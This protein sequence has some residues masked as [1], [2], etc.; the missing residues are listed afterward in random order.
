MRVPLLELQKSEGL[1]R[2]GVRAAGP[3]M[4]RAR[5]FTGGERV[6]VRR[7]EDDERR[8]FQSGDGTKEASAGAVKGAPGGACW[9]G[10][11]VLGAGGAVGGDDMGV[12]NSMQC[13]GLGVGG[14][15]GDS[16]G[17]AGCCGSQLLSHNAS[18]LT[19]AELGGAGPQLP[20]V[21]SSLV[22]CLAGQ[23][24][25]S[26]AP[27]PCET[28]ETVTGRSS[29]PALVDPAAAALSALGAGD[30]TAQEP[31]SQ[32]NGA[33]DAPVTGWH[34]VR[35]D[36]AEDKWM[37]RRPRVR[38]RME[39]NPW[40]QVQDVTWG[41]LWAGAQKR[42]GEEEKASAQSWVSRAV[43]LQLSWAV[44][45]STEVLRVRL[46]VK[47]DEWDC[48]LRVHGGD[49]PA[50]SLGDDAIRAMAHAGWKTCARTWEEGE[51]ERVEPREEGGEVRYG[52]EEM[53]DLLESSD[54]EGSV[55]SDSDSDVEDDAI[56]NARARAARRE[57]RFWRRLVKR[58][59]RGAV[60][61]EEPGGLVSGKQ[62]E[63]PT[64]VLRD[65]E[66]LQKM[67]QDEGC[68]GLEAG[69]L[70]STPDD[71]PEEFKVKPKT[72]KP[73]G[74]HEEMEE[75]LKI[76]P[77]CDSEVLRWIKDK[78]VVRAPEAAQGCRMRNGKVARDQPLAL[79]Q[80]MGKRL[81]NGTFRCASQEDCVNLVSLN[82]VDKP[83]AEPPYRLTVW[84]KDLNEALSKWSVRYEGVHKLG[85][86][87]W[88]GAW[89]VCIDL[90]SGYDAMGLEESTKHLFAARFYAEAEFIAEL[91]AE[92]LLVEGCL[93]EK[94]ASGGA[95]VFVEPNTL[96]QGFSWACA[97]FSKCVRQMVREWR[98]KGLSVCHLIDD[99]LFAFK[100]YA[101]AIWGRDYI[102]SYLEAK[103]WCVS[104]LKAVLTPTQRLKFLGF[105]VDT[106]K[107]RLFLD[108]QKVVKIEAVLQQ[109][110]STG[111]LQETHRSLASV[112]GK[113]VATGPAIPPAR[114]LTRHIYKDVS[115]E[116]ADYDQP[117][118]VRPE[119]LEEMQ[120]AL[121]YLRRLNKYGG[122]IRRKARMCQMRV[123]SDASQHGY[124][125]RIDGRDVRDLKWNKRSRAV[126]AQ[127]T[128]EW[129]HQVHRELAAVREALQKEAEHLRGK[130]V[131]WFTDARAVET[132]INEG[133]GSSDVMSEM[134]ADI[135][136][137]CAAEG[138][139]LRAEHMAGVRMVATGVDSMSRA[140]EFTMHARVYA[141]LNR[142]PRWGRRW[143]FTGFEV[144]LCASQKTAKCE[145]YY[146]RGGLGEGSLG[147]ARTA[148][149]RKDE[150]HYVVPPT[151]FVE[152]A[153]GLLAETGVAAIVVVPMWVGK[154]WNVWLRYR[155]EDIEELPWSEGQPTW[156][157]VADKKAKPHIVANQ[158]QFVVFAVDFRQ[159]ER[160]REEPLKA[161]R[162]QK[163]KQ[164]QGT[165]TKRLRVRWAADEKPG[166]QGYR[167]WRN[168]AVACA[169]SPQSRP[170]GWSR[171]TTGRVAMAAPVNMLPARCSGS[172]R[173]GQL[174]QRRQQF[175]VLSLCGGIGT[176]ALALQQVFEIFKVNMAVV[177]YEVEIHE[178]ARRLGTKLGGAALKHKKPH[179]LWEWIEREEEM[180]AWLQVVQPE[181]FIMGFSCQDVSTAF[182]KGRG[183][184]GPKSSIYF[185]GRTI[186]KWALEESRL[187]GSNRQ[188]DSTY[189]CTW[190]KEKHP[191]DW[192]LVTED[193]GCEPQCLN[194]EKVAPARRKRAFWSTFDFLPLARQEDVAGEGRRDV[195]AQ[196]CL[197]GKRQ[198]AY[199]WVEKMPTVM[200]C[201]QRSW[202][203][204]KCVAEWDAERGK[205][206]LGPMRITEAEVA[207]GLP[208]GITE[209][210]DGGE[211]TPHEER[212]RGVGNA[213]QLGIL[214]HVAVSMLVCKGYIT[215]DDVRQKGQIWTVNQDG[216]MSPLQKALQGL[217]EAVDGNAAE[218]LTVAGKSKKVRGKPGRVQP[219]KRQSSAPAVHEGMRKRPRRGQLRLVTMADAYGRV[220]A[221]G[222][223]QLR[224][225]NREV[226]R[227]TM[228]T[229]QWKDRREQLRAVTVDCLIMSKSEKTWGSY[230]HW[231]RVFEAYCDCEGCYMQTATGKQLA[232]LLQEALSDLF[233]QGN[234]ATGSLRLM[235]TAV[236]GWLKAVR[237]IDV[238][239]ICPELALLLDGFEKKIGLARQKKP[240]TTEV[241]VA[242][243]MDASVPEG[244]GVWA[245]RYG[246]LKWMQWVAIVCAAWSLF[247]RRQ[248][249]LELQLCDV[250]W[251]EDGASFLIRKTKND[252]KS[253]TKSPRME[254]DSTLSDRC[255]LSYVKQYVLSMHGEKGLRK[256]EG[257]TKSRLP[258]ERCVA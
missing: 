174:Q 155:A 108:T 244:V 144:D 247:L 18:R 81:R 245:G 28:R 40:L 197:E 57:E 7:G 127:W 125:Y 242:A 109:I 199:K 106:L 235:V 21:G 135:W 226:G 223:P 220:D 74:I 239:Q 55:S 34:E 229:G 16:A 103:G 6:E 78:I 63:V 234:Y 13:M 208:R 9:N 256:A 90:E 200:A 190:F 194:A 157:D 158:W 12:V 2:R 151:G 119:S 14:A 187:E 101:L 243:F 254:Y 123:I 19:V 170:D 97:I 43:A 91:E 39:G 224:L 116:D 124:G 238:R 75:W 51:E 188:L 206:R 177:V 181:W 205:W 17:A 83:S 137:F 211:A 136:W 184:Q 232:A 191:R 131:L 241:E 114:M 94:D 185:A 24:S 146:S 68:D 107:M 76:Q 186:H 84:P 248:E 41:V 5:T 139:T 253:R 212:W 8:M 45:A 122:P 59:Q 70:Y 203:M 37:S 252:T 230:A 227:S 134:A 152:Q 138:I 80:L 159:G 79:Q 58:H 15:G 66:S 62:W 104:W 67:L 218:K 193:T 23:S 171:Q 120:L 56:D 231:V 255:M 44:E 198:P 99:L 53:P 25:T 167:S 217:A 143:G 161:P 49:E 168:G 31:R 147:D 196:T 130:D 150:L 46:G 36:G 98:A 176:V 246:S 61:G 29:Q 225:L 165:F 132:Y 160:I 32:L 180:R 1:A 251:D 175:V 121:K 183:L 163:D 172:D 100:T 102:L 50:L 237:R 219:A 54:D 182:K 207:M 149:L 73:E 209:E 72:F 30:A 258:A 113:L 201:G 52:E 85:L 89:M 210:V 95:E 105:V 126:A 236:S 215:R 26:L 71:N 153:L 173:R 64:E 111:G 42:R 4:E 20:A 221:K 213:I 118:E 3:Q 169:G 77:R 145:R 228:P 88:E 240:P 60:D 154:E 112:A 110:I 47:G 65:G 148:Q 195:A 129:E 164:Q 92:G 162:R 86:V 204:A 214:K 87:L 189:E 142:D 141:E 128:E 216:P 166:G 82:L 93:G 178:W 233:Y 133:T 156:M 250:T 38:L 179:D 257:C 192:R 222:V 96:P 69:P 27:R 48:E 117:A 249:I 22:S 10:S 140:S 202:N 11:A 115:P 33:F 35:H